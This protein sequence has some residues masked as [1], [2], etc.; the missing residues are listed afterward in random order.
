MT[1][2]TVLTHNDLQQQDLSLFVDIIYNNFIYLADFPKLLHTKNNIY[3]TFL[4]V[5]MIIILYK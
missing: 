4:F 5:K 1:K 2:I 3:D